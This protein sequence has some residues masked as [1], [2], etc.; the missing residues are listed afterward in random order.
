MTGCSINGVPTYLGPMT[1]MFEDG[2]DMEICLLFQ[3]SITP[4]EGYT[5]G[6]LVLP[7]GMTAMSSSDPNDTSV[8]IGVL[9]GSSITLSATPATQ[10]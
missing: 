5:A 10:A 7:E 4:D 3:V 8:T 6:E 1:G 2:R 9:L